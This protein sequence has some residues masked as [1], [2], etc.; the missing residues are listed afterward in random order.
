MRRLFL[1][2]ATLILLVAAVLRLW[3]LSSYPP[4]PHYD[5]A[6]SLLIT[7]SIAF[8]GARFFPIV[9]AYQ[10]REVLYMYLN[11]PL[12]HL[13]G[14]DILTLRVGSVFINLITAA[15]TIAL[16]R[17]MFR[18]QRGVV[19]GLVMGVLIALSFPQVWLARQAFRA[20]AQPMIQAL[21]LLF[22]WRGL[23][24][25]GRW[26]AVGGLF[27]GAVL[28][29]YMA[30]RLFPLWLLLG[31]L[32]LLLADRRRW[33]LRLRQGLVF[34]GVMALTALPLLVYAVQRPDIFFA[35]LEEVTQPEQSVTLAESVVLHLR[36][37]F[38]EGDPYLRYNI[39]HRPY[40]T[41][42]EGLLM[43]A[44]MGTAA[45]RLFA[46]R[47]LDAPERAAYALA[48]LSPLMVIP[49][50]RMWL[51]GSPPTEITLGITISGDSSAS[52]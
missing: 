51:G 40:L 36:M 31:G 24:G 47:K 3:Q 46:V 27:A 48:L 52:A 14:N 7:R 19:I 8:G 38:L 44:G 29:T 12:L 23:R 33:R 2:L 10:G 45:W 42:L 15:A 1:P 49:S 20:G 50:E 30:S 26:L 9:E 32:A 5:E 6:V 18:G 34:F 35:R 43:L 41:W 25:N 21:A 13:L 22:L 28:Y 39:P 4:G 11:A 16:G 37:F 17:T